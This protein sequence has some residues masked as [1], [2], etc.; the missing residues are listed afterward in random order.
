M[1]LIGAGVTSAWQSYG[2]EAKEM[3]RAQVPSIAWLLPVSSTKQ[4]SESQLTPVA[5][6]TSP[7]LTQQLKPMAIDLAL[8]RR[9]IEE[10]ANQQKEMAERLATLQAVEQY[11]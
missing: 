8:V 2:H 7:E 4:A 5:A 11:C 1:A 10:L 9:S 3:V 6:I